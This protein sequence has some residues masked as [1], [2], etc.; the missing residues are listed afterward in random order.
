MTPSTV[1]AFTSLLLKMKISVMKV[2]MTVFLVMMMDTCVI[3]AVGNLR[4]GRITRADSSI[5]ELGSTLLSSK[6]LDAAMNSARNGS[7]KMRTFHLCK[8]M[9]CNKYTKI[10]AFAHSD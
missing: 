7:H 5:P 9:T 6:N 2:L 8:D 1:Q 4:A 10:C 3:Q